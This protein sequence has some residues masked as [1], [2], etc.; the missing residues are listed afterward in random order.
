M[1]HHGVARLVEGGELP[2][3]LRD[4]PAALFGTCDDLDLGLFQILHG[5]IAPVLPGGQQG[6]LVHQVLKVRSGKARG[7]LGQTLEVHILAQGLALDMDF[8]DLLPALDV[9]KAHVDLT[10][11]PSGTKER[12]VQNVRAV[13][14]SQDHY[15]FVGSKAV[16]LHQ[17]LVQCLLPLVVSAAHACA[18]LAAHGVDLVD[19]DDGG[20]GPLGLL[21]E[22]PDAACANAHIELHEVRAGNGQK[23]HPRLAGNSL[24]KEGL[25]GARRAHQQHAL[26]DAGA[27]GDEF[28]G[29][30]QDLHDLLELLLLL[31]SSGHV[32]EGD[33]LV[34]VGKAPGL[35]G[36]EAGHAVAS[37][38]S[39]VL[40]G[41]EVPEAPDAKHRQEGGQQELR[42]VG[43]VVLPEV[44]VLD[45]APGLLVQDGISHV[46]P[47]GG[48]VIELIAHNIRD[49]SAVRPLL[50]L[51]NEGIILDGDG[52]H[53]LL[54]DELADIFVAQVLPGGVHLPD[55][56]QREQ[57]QG[58]EQKE[59][60]EGR[61]VF[62][63]QLGSSFIPCGL[64]PP[65]AKGLF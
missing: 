56:A 25:A 62:L 33:F 9:G 48:K 27:D 49:H 17:E 52:L 3:R 38:A 14:G 4:D 28:L 34:L 45:N 12:R 53:P 35:G 64:W 37:H 41:D 40:H 54:G 13:G 32:L 7:A 26:G 47:E 55:P 63:G 16:H 2:L 50:E 36:G 11:E 29:V 23:A 15:A 39:L 22:V 6:R 31:V 42:P 58:D 10:V 30:F 43:G 18:A 24:G 1:H 65:C 61:W 21:K 20:R 44:I 8:Q 46:V 51:Q 59:V 60:G 5:D 57:E 19:K